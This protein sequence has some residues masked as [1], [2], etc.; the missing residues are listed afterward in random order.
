MDSILNKGLFFKVRK[1]TKINNI[2]LLFIENI[3]KLPVKI[4]KRNG[5]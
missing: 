5:I 4:K 2:N 3:L 1:V